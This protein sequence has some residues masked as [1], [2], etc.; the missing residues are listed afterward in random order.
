MDMRLE[1]NMQ[2]VLV[3]T[4]GIHNGHPHAAW[5]TTCSMDMEM[6][7]QHDGHIIDLDMQHA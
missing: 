5:T 1:I 4:M 2:H 7:E 3:H 6:D